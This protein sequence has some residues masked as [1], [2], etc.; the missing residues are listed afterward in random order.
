M[1]DPTPNLRWFAIFPDQPKAAVQVDERGDLLAR[2][3]IKGMGS[4]GATARGTT[5][6]VESVRSG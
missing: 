5:S 2:R 4:S 6:G 3:E 1:S